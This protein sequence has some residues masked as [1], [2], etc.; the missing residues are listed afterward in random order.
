MSRET[1]NR[2]KVKAL[3]EAYSVTEITNTFSQ[4][5]KKLLSLHKCSADDFSQ[6]NNDFKDL[7]KK[8]EIISNNVNSIFDILNTTN[9]KELYNQINSFYDDLKDQLEIFDQKLSLS[10]GFL[11]QLMSQLRFVFFPIKNFGQN[12]TSLKFLLA[13]LN[14]SLVISDNK[15]EFINRIK[16]IEEK[17]NNIRAFSERLSKNLNHLRKVAKISYSNFS[18]VKDQNSINVEDFLSDVKL[19]IKSIEDRSKDNNDC[20]PKIRRK[21]DKSANSISDIV[22]KLQ[23][24]DIIKQKME[25][26]QDTHK[27][28]INELNKF[29][30]APNDEKHLNEKAKFFLR[31]RDIAGLQAAQ[32]IHA[33]KEYQSA[34]GIIVN[35][36]MSV[37]DNMKVISEMCGKVKNEDSEDE[38]EIFNKIIDQIALTEENFRNKFEQNNKLNNDINV[39]EHHLEQSEKYFF[40]LEDFNSDLK[41]VL[42]EY[43]KNI[44]NYSDSDD[45]IN[46]SLIQINSLIEE[47]KKNTTG[48]NQVKEQLHPIKKRVQGFVNEFR[49]LSLDAD[50]NKVKEVVLKI[51]SLGTDVDN[52]LQEN[53][54]ISSE[55][56]ES[57]KKSISDIKY[58]DFF[59]N[60]IDEIITE[61]NTVNFKLKVDS[62]D[63]DASVEDNLKT[64][65]E[66]YT[67]ETEYRIHDQVSKGQ[68]TDI[69]IE[70]EEDGEIEFF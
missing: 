16:D 70:N 29:E 69:N 6:L 56:L 43:L 37:G 32:L 23:Y 13:N 44:R 5:D 59:E 12:L 27:D 68:E 17:I 58:Y 18:Q 39:I 45:N 14:L 35:N 3:L 19:K 54:Q 40:M 42:D 34:L 7:Y 41:L 51:N 57:I 26:I 62:P 46:G 24:Q 30:D 48:L 33:N 49:N 67:M 21:T 25:H 28:L 11:D 2:I 61:L 65:K 66:Y 1:E 55:V 63:E 10:M 31:I 38:L 50:F 47:I 15:P 20:I 64:I 8:S 22:K 36:F 53:R 4:I 52:K 9:N 60:I